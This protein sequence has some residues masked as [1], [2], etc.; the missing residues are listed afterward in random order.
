MNQMEGLLFGVFL[1]IS[2][3]GIGQTYFPFPDDS[4]KWCI[5]YEEGSEDY[6]N[7][8]Y[9]LVYSVENDT[10]INDLLY[11]N[12]GL[13]QIWKLWSNY[14]GYLGGDDSDFYLGKV[15][16]FREEDKKIF[17]YKFLDV[18]NVGL[19]DF[20]NLYIEDT[21]EVILYDFG[22]DIGDQ[23]TQ[24]AWWTGDSAIRTVVDTS[25]I[26]LADGFYHKQ[27]HTVIDGS[28]H[29]W[30]EGI[31]S[32]KGL[33]DPYFYEFEWFTF[34]LNCF[35]TN[36]N[37]I[38]GN[39]SCDF[40]EIELGVESDNDL[41]NIYISPNPFRDYI[42]VSNL[43]V[44]LNAR[45]EI[46]DIVGRKVLNSEFINLEVN[47]ANLQSGIFYLIII[48]DDVIIYSQKIIKI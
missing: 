1:T 35:W 19:W 14:Y 22:M 43:P 5:T 46:Y 45:L 31:G 24:Y 9:G 47:V 10:I 15:G 2:L 25:S 23:M 27:L 7:E 36:N 11:K 17:F 26:L 20:G 29:T 37:Y 40:I 3:T 48:S 41:N 28:F 39:D 13:T 21:V 30:I 44:G 42:S 33:F 12:I 16:C 32:D 6:Y 18:D 34:D 4:A 38:Y 8:Q